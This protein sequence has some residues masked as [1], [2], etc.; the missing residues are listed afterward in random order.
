MNAFVGKLTR[1]QHLRSLQAQGRGNSGTC[2]GPQR[3]RTQ[4]SIPCV[5]KGHREGEHSLLCL[6][7]EKANFILFK[8]ITEVI[9]DHEACTEARKGRDRISHLCY[10]KMTDLIEVSVSPVSRYDH[11]FNCSRNF[12]SPL[13]R[14]KARET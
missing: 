9:V 13:G 1:L 3:G 11:C 14:G 2:Q 6:V 8:V 7:E 4:P 5:I 10:P 12:Q